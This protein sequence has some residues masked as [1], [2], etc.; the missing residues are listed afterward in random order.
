MNFDISGILKGWDYDPTSV[1]ARW[2]KG[3]DGRL[4]VQL[5]LDLG[6]FQM[7]AEG[8]PDGSRPRGYRSLLDYYRSI[9]KTSPEVHN[10]LKLDEAACAELQQEAMQYYYRYLSFYALH[11]FEGVVNDTEHNLGL[12]DLVSRHVKDEDV[13]W[14]FLQFYPYIRMM[15]ARARAE[16]AVAEKQHEE[17]VKS[18]QQALDDIQSFWEEYGDTDMGSGRQEIELLTDMLKQVRTRKP[19]SM[20][21][22]LRDQLQ[23][24]IASEDY[25]KAAVLR[26]KLN[27]LGRTKDG[28]SARS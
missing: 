27:T 8:R 5:R 10:A 9:E 14:Q 28:Q 17:A 13:A 6:L 26:D 21:D 2:V 23:Q 3:A 16:K 15:N 20:A 7:E 12:V 11:H 19:R 18:L 4:K 24:A 22:K 1:S 25:E